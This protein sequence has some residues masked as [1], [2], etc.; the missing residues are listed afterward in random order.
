MH[1]G[2]ASNR[3]WGHGKRATQ[4]TAVPYRDVF[5]ASTAAAAAAVN[6]NLV[7]SLVHV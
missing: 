2:L 6:S 7:T 5:W 4:Y 3:I 1:A